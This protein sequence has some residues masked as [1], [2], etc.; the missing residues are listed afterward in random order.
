ML[1]YRATYLKIQELVL[2]L[3]LA[4]HQYSKQFVLMIFGEGGDDYSVSS[5]QKN[6]Q[7]LTRKYGIICLGFRSRVYE[8]E[9]LKNS[10]IQQKTLHANIFNSQL[11]AQGLRCMAYLNTWNGRAMNSRLKLF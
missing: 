3:G 1:C 2:L 7:R 4:P 10:Q 5:F 11:P 8:T 9:F 6:S